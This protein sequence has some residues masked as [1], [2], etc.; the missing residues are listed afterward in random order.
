MQPDG[1]S[2]ISLKFSKK[3]RITS[4]SLLEELVTANQSVF[5]FP[6]KCYFKIENTEGCNKIAIAVPKRLFKRAV[7]RN[8]IKRLI[9][10]AYRL[11]NKKILK[12]NTLLSHRNISLLLVFVGKEI[13]PYAQMEGKL[14]QL[15]SKLSEKIQCQK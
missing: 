11:N 2:D 9:R 7:D 12:K 13:L 4:H 1:V 14:I 10:E 15:L 3:E 8:R 6:C 5:V